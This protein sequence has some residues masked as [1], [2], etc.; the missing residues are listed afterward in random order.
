VSSRKNAFFASIVVHAMLLGVVL[1]VPLIFP[2]T[3]KMKYQYVELALVSPRLTEP[4]TLSPP[5]PQL[6]APKLQAPARRAP[7]EVRP[8]LVKQQKPAER[9]IVMPKPVVPAAPVTRSAGFDR[10]EPEVVAPAPRAVV[11]TGL[12]SDSAGAPGEAGAATRVVQTGG[13]GDPNGVSAKGRPDKIANIASLGSFDL[14]AGGSGG[15]G[16]R[17]GTGRYVQAAGFSDLNTSAAGTGSGAGARN[18]APTETPVEILSKPRPEYTEMARQ[19]RLEGEV[20]IRVLFRANGEVRV[21]DIV[22][23]L[24]HG[25]DQNAVRAAQQIRFKPATRQNQPVDSTATVHIVF[26]LAY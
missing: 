22:R 2:D 7:I 16:G 8:P 5:E 23:S 18:A 24:G 1:L 13:F 12:F 6:V 14:P 25:L 11:R 3:I 4:V 19:L 9:E 17:D 26:Q 10:P 21:L 20:L 15:G